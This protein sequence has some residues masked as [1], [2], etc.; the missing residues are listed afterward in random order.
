MAKQPARI[1]VSCLFRLR[2][3]HALGVLSDHG[4]NVVLRGATLGSCE[5][6]F[7][8]LSASGSHHIQQLFNGLIDDLQLVL[9]QFQCDCICIAC[10]LGARRGTV[11]VA[12]PTMMSVPTV[13]RSHRRSEVVTMV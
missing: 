4:Q 13:D 5:K 2:H 9:S 6:G 8:L 10:V 7:E 3:L 1:S 11:V 12:S